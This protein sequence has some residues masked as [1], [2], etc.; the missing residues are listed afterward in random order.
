MDIDELVKQELDAI[1]TAWA[2]AMVAND[3]DRIGSFMADEWVI[4]SERGIST[5][6]AFLMF[7]RSGQLTHSA[8]EMSGAPRVKVYGDTAVLTCRV[9]NTAH[10]GGQQFDADEWTSDVFVKRD[11]KWLCALSHITTVDKNFPANQQ[12]VKDV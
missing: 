7:V 4:V 12:E 10:F 6:E 11:G 1:G 5:K 3:A 2:E 9:T 8:F